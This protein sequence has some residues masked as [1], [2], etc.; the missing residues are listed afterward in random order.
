[1]SSTPSLRVVVGDDSYLVREGIVR[2]L[3]ES[4]RTEVVGAC[5]DYDSLHETI[6]QTRPD[7]VVTDIRMPPTG[8]DEGI[9]LAAELSHTHPEIGVVVLSQHA[10]LAY[11]RA[12]FE[13]ASTRR[14]YILK[15][16]VADRSFLLDAVE[17]VARERPMLDPQIAAMVLG[18]R[19]TP[20]YGIDSLSA[21]ESQV[22]ALVADG[23]SNA[24]I[25]G[26]L[27]L[28]PRSVERRINGIFTKLDLHDDGAVNRR[29]LA[30]LMYVRNDA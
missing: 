1:M 11:A 13:V 20:G 23:A 6:E 8:T 22:L 14:A 28:T 15:D 29:V 18:P 19:V 24:A 10:Q 5:G 25:A 7:V 26:K 12:L 30:A 3:D 17:S 27:D 9:R 2:A 4:G 16:R 21:G